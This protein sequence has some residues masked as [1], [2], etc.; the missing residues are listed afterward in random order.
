MITNHNLVKNSVAASDEGKARWFRMP[1]AL[2]EDHGPF[3]V[4][5]SG[6]L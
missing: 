4:P 5:T 1:A 3:L 6:S 2:A